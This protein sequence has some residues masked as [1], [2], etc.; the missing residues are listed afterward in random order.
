MRSPAA[1]SIV[2]L[3]AA[4][5]IAAPLA[6]AQQ[7]E[8]PSSQPPSASV[9]AKPATDLSDKKLDA[10]A[11]A[12]KGVTAVKEAYQQK[13]S[14]ASDGDKERI[15]DEAQAAM[16]KAVTD[17]GLSVDEYTAILQVAQNDTAVKN[18]IL[19]RLK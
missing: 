4:F 14:E 10:A 6:Q 9:P 16:T 19:E 8:A 7:T 2:A 3:S 13:L 18:K 1:L 5:A 12:V 15:V 11:A 17:Q